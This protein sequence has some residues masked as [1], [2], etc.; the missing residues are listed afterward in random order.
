MRA[1]VAD[2][3]IETSDGLYEAMLDILSEG[4]PVVFS[5]ADVRKFLP[6]GRRVENMIR[7]MLIRGE[8]VKLGRDRFTRA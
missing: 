3:P 2:Q 4:L 6:Y 7:E 5:L 8:L 1:F